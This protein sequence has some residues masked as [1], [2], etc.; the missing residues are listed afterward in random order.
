MELGIVGVRF[1]LAQLLV[2]IAIEQVNALS[3]A[4]DRRPL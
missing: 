2:V 1:R 3:N 4:L